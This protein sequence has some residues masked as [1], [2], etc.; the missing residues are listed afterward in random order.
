MALLE[1][2]KDRI[3]SDLSDPDLNGL[4]S[5]A[6]SAIAERFG[7]PR[8]PEAPITVLRDG[9]RRKIDLIRPLDAAETFTVTELWAP[10]PDVFSPDDDED[11]TFGVSPQPLVLATNDVRIWHGG[12]TLERLLTGTNPRREW[13]PIV[14]VTYV[15][16]DDQLRRDEVAVKLV[17]LAASYEGI[18]ERQVGDVRTIHTANRSGS[19]TGYAEERERLLASL[20]PRRGLLIR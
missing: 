20:E 6:Q 12:R 16:L 13:A 18:S 1:T 14:Q 15:P 17:V 8:D 4:I 5:E 19:P 10:I 3:E 11:L 2:V 7:P 9:L